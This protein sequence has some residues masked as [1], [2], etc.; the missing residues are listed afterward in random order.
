M[1][2]G[3]GDAGRDD[4]VQGGLAGVEGVIVTTW[5][6]SRPRP[7]LQASALERQTIVQQWCETPPRIGR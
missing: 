2:V 5:A 6:A 1:E 3:V 7:S 4:A